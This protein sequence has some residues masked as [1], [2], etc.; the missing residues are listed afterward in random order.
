MLQ[1][2]WHIANVCTATGTVAQ[3]SE[4]AARA[5]AEEQGLLFMEVSAKSGEGVHELF[6]QLATKVPRSGTPATPQRQ[7]G[8]INVAGSG[9]ASTGA[10]RR[11]STAAS[12]CCPA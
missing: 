2:R 1:C 10:S 3:V 8:T 5:Y 4:E 11:A 7:P 9:A 6:K 12:Q